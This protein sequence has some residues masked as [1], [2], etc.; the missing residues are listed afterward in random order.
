MYLFFKR[1]AKKFYCIAI[2]KKLTTD[3]YNYQLSYKYNFWKHR[4]TKGNRYFSF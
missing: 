1:K 2:Y 3:L 4:K